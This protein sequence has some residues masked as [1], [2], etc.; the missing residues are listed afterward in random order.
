MQKKILT[1]PIKIALSIFLIGSLFKVMHWPGAK[2]QIIVGA[3]LVAI[4]Y[5]IRFLAKKEKDAI[6]LVKF[7]W[8]VA[9]AYFYVA[10]V[11]HW[12]SLNYGIY[13]I[14]IMGIY[15]LYE[16]WG[17]IV[18]PSWNQNIK[19]HYTGIITIAFLSIFGGYSFK[20][21]H[22]PYANL[23]IIIGYV[24]LVILL[25]TGDFILK[26]SSKKHNPHSDIID[27]EMITNK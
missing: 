2:M 22:W 15:W 14:D 17:N 3:G 16:E 1:Y 19:N 9:A 4:L 27:D 7:I 20:I 24:G 21:M 6:D 18:K 25:L 12:P 13:I 11:F 26:T 5:T 10:S 23:M 8:I